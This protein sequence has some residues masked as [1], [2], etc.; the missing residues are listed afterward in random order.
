MNL[1]QVL[2]LCPLRLSLGPDP[3]P[4]PGPPTPQAIE[5]GSHNFLGS[6][7]PFSD[8]FLLSG[9]RVLQKWDLE[10]EGGEYLMASGKGTKIYKR[11][12]SGVGE[13]Q[14]A[15]DTITSSGRWAWLSTLRP[16]APYWGIKV[17]CFSSPIPAP[18]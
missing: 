1:S 3:M 5:T 14:G 8:S 15:A 7:S 16:P 6:P 18:S 12:Q 10:E 11:L 4:S 9:P 17:P 2:P 13:G